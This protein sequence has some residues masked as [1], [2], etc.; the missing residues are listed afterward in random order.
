MY[1]LT[2]KLY[3][4]YKLYKLN[5]IMIISLVDINEDDDDNI[6]ENNDNINDE[7]IRFLEFQIDCLNKKKLSICERLNNFLL[8]ETKEDAKLIFDNLD[9][10]LN[11]SVH[12]YYL[13]L[14][15]IQ[16]TEDSKLEYRIEYIIVSTYIS[17]DD[18]NKSYLQNSHEPYLVEDYY[19]SRD[20]YVSER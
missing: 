3:K 5:I 19:F 9:I 15:A 20:L 13:V 11:K 14:S 16:V 6:N 4:H 12:D 7:E 10:I 8:Y 18:S 2:I 1:T 17:L